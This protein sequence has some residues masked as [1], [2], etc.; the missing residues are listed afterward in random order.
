MIF[1]QLWTVRALSRLCV[2]LIRTM[3]ER[4]FKTGVEKIAD[5]LGEKKE[6]K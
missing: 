3:N 6:G 4:M 2:C 1:R 5:L